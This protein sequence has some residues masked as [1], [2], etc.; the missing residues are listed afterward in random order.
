MGKEKVF[1]LEIIPYLQFITCA[2]WKKK[3]STY[4]QG[5]RPLFLTLA[6]ELT[7]WQSLP[8]LLGPLP[9]V[10]EILIGC[11]PALVFALFVSAL[12]PLFIAR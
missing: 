7:S 2:Y 12:T 3:T 4:L 11:K 1:K 10:T 5:T 6:E 9:K 8:E